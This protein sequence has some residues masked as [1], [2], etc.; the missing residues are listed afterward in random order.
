MSPALRRTLA[1]SAIVGLVLLA[2]SPAFSAGFLYWDDDKNFFENTL[3]RGL[4]ADHLR[5]MATTFRGGPYQPLSWLSLAIDH[6]FFGMAPRGYHAVNVALHAGTAVAFYFLA[7]KLLIRE[8]A[9]LA[10]A[11]FFAVHP[12]RAESVAWITERR[13]VL[14]GLFYVLSV[15]AYVHVDPEDRSRRRRILL[16]LSLVSFLLGLL[17][18]A[19]G[20]TLPLVLLLLDRWLLRREGRAVWFEKAPF[21]LLALVFAA[22]AWLGQA[23]VP[24]EL[25]GLGE[26][27]ISERIAQAAY[28][29]VFYPAK[30]FVPARLSP[31]Y[32]LP[33]PFDWTSGRF[34][35]ASVVAAVATAG[36]FLARRSLPAAWTAWAAFLVILAPVSG[37]VQAGPQLVADRYSYLSCMP[38]A[39]LAAGALFAALP[40]GAPAAALAVVAALGVLTWEQTRLWRDT[41]TLFT[42]ALELDPE[43]PIAHDVVGR[44]LAMRG[45]TEKA[46][47]HYRR[48]I[49][50]APDRAV[51]HNNLGLLL[52]QQGRVDDAIVEFRAALRAQDDSA[53]A[54]TNLGAALLR[55]GDL[56]EAE[57][58]LREVAAGKPRDPGARTNL[59]QVL[60][61][62]NRLDEA[63]VELNAAL[64]ASPN[65]AEAHEGL[66][67]VYAKLGRA[68][69]AE[70]HRRAAVRLRAAR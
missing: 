2:F 20:M 30:T 42:H 17:S 63:I 38:F 41:E 15:L 28:A 60:I 21:A 39:L 68:S 66:A 23:S 44:M 55:R 25:R 53:R 56:A 14:S 18:K 54:R 48:S 32:D 59:A 45:E 49:E 33:A 26:H 9:A 61:A 40:R 13:D 8:A 35:G 4:S 12:L 52:L 24:H 37:L 6:A 51:P 19:S 69:L 3:W 11:L 27:G 31:I 22:L 64:A 50:L 70:E 62:E 57:R 29:A 5:W 58:V 7:R 10:A 36:A 1:L 47:E 43:S 34:L 65:L 67:Q 16:A 46:A